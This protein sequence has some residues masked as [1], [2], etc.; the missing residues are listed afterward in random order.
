MCE[1]CESESRDCW[2]PV[3]NHPQ[4]PSEV[5]GNWISLERC[6]SCETLWVTSPYEPYASFLYKAKWPWDS[7]RFQLVHD[8]DNGQLLHDWHCL[9]LR[10]RYF[11]R[12]FDSEAVEAHRTRSYGHY[13]PIDL[14]ISCSLDEIHRIITET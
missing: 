14:P 5:N 3:A 8:L 13:N 1:T 11:S 2:G 4:L 7:A 9:A 10:S 12:A 6:P